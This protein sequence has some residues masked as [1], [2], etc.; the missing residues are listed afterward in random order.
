MQGKGGINT[1]L[2]QRREQ[3]ILIIVL[4]QLEIGLWM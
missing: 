4:H 2:Q 3:K 1:N